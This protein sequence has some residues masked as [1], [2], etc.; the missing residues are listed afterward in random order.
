M[1]WRRR[2]RDEDLEREVRSHLEAEAEELRESGLAAEDAHY[3]ARRAFG[4]TALT[5][6]P[7]AKHGD[8]TGWSDSSR[9]LP[10]HFRAF[11]RTPGFTAVVILTLALGIGATTAIFSIVNAVLLNPLPY[12]NAD[13]LVVIWEKLVRNPKGTAVF[14]SYRDFKTWKNASR[15]FELLAPATWG[16]GGQI[17]IG[18]GAARNVLAMPV[19]IDFFPL[20]GVTPELGRTFQQDDLHRGC[21]V[22]LKHSFWLSAFRGQKDA[23]G[24]HV[25]FSEQACTVTGVMPARFTFYPDAASMWMLITPDSPIGRDP[26]RADVGVFG[27]LKPGVSIE[28][29]QK[30]VEALYRNQHEKDPD[31]IVRVPVV[32]RWQNSLPIC[33]G[34]TCGSAS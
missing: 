12:P 25:S 23:V 26:E 1:R 17:L 33:Q 29:A 27:L 24:K 11:G 7:S 16:T 4:N 15:S 21:T 18:N 34:R 31:G 8:G 30:E 22:V 20:L 3:A 5:R 14:D 19:G 2:K 13:R 28:R 10:T 9:M 32:F 6:K